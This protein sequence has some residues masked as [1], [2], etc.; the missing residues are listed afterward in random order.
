MLR[1]VLIRLV[2]GLIFLAVFAWTV[3]IMLFFMNE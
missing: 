3:R 2:L 1:E